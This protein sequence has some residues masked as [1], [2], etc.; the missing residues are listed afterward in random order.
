MTRLGAASLS[1]M[2]TESA[3]IPAAIVDDPAMT[4][5][6]ELPALYRSILDQLAVLQ[7]L[8][9][10]REAARI[11]LA[12][13]VVY[14]AAWDEGGRNRLLA[15]RARANRAIT[16]QRRPRGWTLRRRSVPAR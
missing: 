9:E 16:D 4:L 11:R 3:P 6:E 14:S 1:L 7:Q 2:E 12:T 10:W 5:A 13:T 15:L 8:G